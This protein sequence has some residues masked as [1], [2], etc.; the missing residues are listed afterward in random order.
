MM[1]NPILNK[2]LTVGSRSIKMS[3][4]LML[5]NLIL[6]GIAII[7]LL[8]LREESAYGGA[9]YQSLM[10]L[11]PILATLQCFII[12]FMIP[13][14]TASSIAG[15][16]ERQTL[17]VMLTTPISAFSIVLG[18]VF[19]A[20]AQVLMYVLSSIP[21]MSL[22]FIIGG[23][24][25]SYILGFIVMVIYASFYVGAVGVYCSAKKK[26][27]IA[28]VISS[29]IFIAAS[30]VGTV[31]GFSICIGII[32]SQYYATYNGNG[33][34]GTLNYGLTPLWMLFNPAV[35]VANYVCHAFFGYSIADLGASGKDN[36]PASMY[37]LTQ[38]WNVFGVI[39]NILVAFWFI[40]RAAKNINPLKK[41]KSKKNQG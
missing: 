28:S 38:H 19:S 17:D 21:I 2:E 39:V 31:V 13:V 12:L 4:H 10:A 1:M 34:T 35:P 6:G 9:D 41:V 27:T 32:Q 15:E 8:I 3:I 30:M 16:R 37:F 33:Y 14:L 29:F 7:T 40:R 5:Y 18:K 20:M 26:K 23:M 36:L 22:A 11:F 24:S 25:W